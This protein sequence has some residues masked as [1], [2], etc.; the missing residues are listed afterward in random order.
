MI[1]D[2]NATLLYLNNSHWNWPFWGHAWDW[3]SVHLH[4]TMWPFLAKPHKQGSTDDEGVRTLPLLPM[5]PGFKSPHWR[6][7]SWTWVELVVRSLLCFERFFSRHYGFPVFKHHHYQI[8]IRRGMV[9]EEPFVYVLS[10]NLYLFTITNKRGNGISKT[11]LW[12]YFTQHRPCHT[13]S[14]KLANKLGYFS[15][16]C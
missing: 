15:Y 6:H 13:H 5:W 9:D 11:V 8:P 7:M 3:V 12:C 1:Y 14:L 2:L 16:W 4:R 10:L